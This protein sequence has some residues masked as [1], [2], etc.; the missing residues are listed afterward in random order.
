MSK[1]KK[2]TPKAAPYFSP[3]KRQCF[4]LGNFDYSV[5]RFMGVD[6]NGNPKERGFADLP[7]VQQDIEVFS[8]NIEQYGF[9][10]DLDILQKTNLSIAGVKK[11]L[12]GYQRRIADNAD[13]NKKTLT[14]LYYG[15][16][17]MMKDNM[18]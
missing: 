18:S 2:V 17:G 8:R 15:G 11:I 9:D 14:V 5:I 10:S 4:I 16:H 12:S 1:V 7:E 3:D 6:S 13:S